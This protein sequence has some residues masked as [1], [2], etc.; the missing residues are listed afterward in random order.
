M[1][2]FLT[3]YFFTAANLAALLL[4]LLRSRCAMK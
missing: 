3:S 2:T 1:N 4:R